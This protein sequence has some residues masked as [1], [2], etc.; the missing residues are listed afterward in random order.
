MKVNIQLGKDKNSINWIL[1]INKLEKYYAICPAENLRNNLNF[2]D[3]EGKSRKSY[4]HGKIAIITILS[5]L[6][7][8]FI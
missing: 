3:L 5:Y 4:R 8:L 7:L 1:S 2:D 6:F